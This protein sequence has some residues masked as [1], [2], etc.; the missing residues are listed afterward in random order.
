MGNRKI[1]DKYIANYS[2]VVMVQPLSKGRYIEQICLRRPRTSDWSVSYVSNSAYHI[3]PY[4]GIFRNCKECGIDN[5]DFDAKFCTNKQQIISDKE[6]AKRVNE[7]QAAN[8]KVKL[9]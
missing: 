6:M 1:T 4:D 9:A 5:E 3:C 2:T 7:C 8:L